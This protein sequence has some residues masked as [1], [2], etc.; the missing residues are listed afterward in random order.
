MAL[1]LGST[2]AQAAWYVEPGGS[3]HTF[4]SSSERYELVRESVSKQ[5]VILDTNGIRGTRSHHSIRTRAGSYEAGGTVV[6]HPDPVGLDLWL[7]RILGG[8]ESADSFP[9]AEALPAFGM[10]FDRVGGTFEYKD[11]YVNRATFRGQQGQLVELEMDIW[12]AQEATGTSA[13]SVSLGT[14]ANNAP[15][16]FSDGV[17]TI[18]SGARTMMDFEC[19]IDNHLERRF[20]NSLVAT[21][22]T[23]Q[24]R[25]VTLR[26]TTPF[27]STE[28]SALYGTA[29]AGVTGTLVLT[30][31]GMS[32]TFTFG[33]LQLP[34]RS[35]NLTSKTEIKLGLEMTARMTGST[36]EI[37][38]THDSVA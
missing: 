20:A 23:P 2:A 32:T 16:V 13:P 35:P 17:L 12:A 37:V 25:T 21:S 14:A 8:T 7:P 30:N 28:L 29:T 26:C 22:I 34:D 31:G 9:L 6:T 5:G 1:T 36:R 38:I 11:C 19:V 18:F 4:D 24:D 27:T 10:L 3:A 33:V 15:Y